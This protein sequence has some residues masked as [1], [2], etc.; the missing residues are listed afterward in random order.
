MRL[1]VAETVLLVVAEMVNA[2]EGKWELAAVPSFRPYLANRMRSWLG[3]TSSGACVAL[4]QPM[5][6]L[7]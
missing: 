5:M 7:V 1:P 4:R 6:D 2:G 3:D